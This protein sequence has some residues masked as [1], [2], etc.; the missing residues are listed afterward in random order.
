MSWILLIIAG[1][2]EIAW[3]AGLKHSAGFTRPIPTILTLL[4]AA[5]SLA[6]LGHAAK[7]LPLGTAYAIWTAIG[8][9]GAVIFG[10]LLFGEA[11]TAGQAICLGLILAGVIGL[12]FFGSHGAA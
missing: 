2:L 7:T 11:I 8:V 12:Q 10:A 5:L 6:L 9:G 3:V 4:A 1:L